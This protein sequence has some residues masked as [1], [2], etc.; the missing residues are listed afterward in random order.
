MREKERVAP[1]APADIEGAA[2]LQLSD[3]LDEKS[4]G[5]RLEFARA[6]VRPAV[7][8]PFIVSKD[9]SQRALCL[10]GRQ[11]SSQEVISVAR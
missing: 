9:E 10:L 3:S 7:M 1:L 6:R 5:F 4:S 11:A 2:R 8:P